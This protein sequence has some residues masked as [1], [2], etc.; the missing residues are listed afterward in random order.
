MKKISRTM[1][2]SLAFLP[3]LCNAGF[4][5]GNDLREWS[6]ALSRANSG[7]YNTIE[8]SAYASL[9][10]GYV[11]GIFD[12]TQDIVVCPPDNIRLI[13]LT[14]IVTNYVNS[15]PE[16]RT[17]PANH[18]VIESMSSAFPCKNQ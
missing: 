3:L 2:L 14:D 16:K 13:Q 4:Y 6:M 10:Q 17:M 7:N 15:N 18:I 11:A 9:F 5:T 8:Q 1:T 12:A